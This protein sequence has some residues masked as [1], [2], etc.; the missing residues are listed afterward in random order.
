MFPGVLFCCC[1]HWK[2]MWCLQFSSVTQSC[3]TLCNPM[4]CSTPGLLSITNSWSLLKLTSI[5]SVIPS[6]HLILCRPL[7][8]P[9][10]IFPSIRVFSF[11]Y[12]YIYIYFYY[13]PISLMNI[14][15]KI[16]NKILANRIQQHIK[17]II[18]HDQVG[19]SQGCKDSSISANQSM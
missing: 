19:L 14:D 7:L 2:T 11:I 17:K 8:L 15:A 16:L 9:P 1:G 3:L 5:E 13:R 10:S 12:I 6:N 4:D 18:H